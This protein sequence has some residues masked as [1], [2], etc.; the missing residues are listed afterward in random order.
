VIAGLEQ[1]EDRL[2][3][4]GPAAI[5]ALARLD[6][7]VLI[8]GV[9]GKMG[10]SLARM[11]VRAS[12]EAGVSRRVIGVS[13]FSNPEPRRQLQ[14]W[15]VE[16]VAGDLFDDRFIRVLPACPHVVYMVG[17]KFG[18]S[19][20]EPITWATN[21]YLPSCVCRRFSDS[22]IA[23]F[24]TGN[25]YRPMPVEGSRGSGE[26]DALAP[27]GEYAMSCLGRERL[28]EYF[29]RTQGTRLT[30]LR[31]NYATEMRY[32]VLVDI[33]QKVWH[34]EEVPLLVGYVNVIWQADANTMA[35]AALA[36]AAS[37]PF[38]VNITGPELISCRRVAERFG[39]LMRKPVRFS[40]TEGSVA[41]HSDARLAH[42]R[43]GV[44]RVGL[45]ELIGWTADWVM[46]NGPTLNKP[47]HYE[48]LDGQF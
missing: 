11:V 10:P 25:V 7:D 2:S 45:D 6:G 29:S 27:V 24:S 35:L 48:V 43:F 4:P 19:G 20:G 44:P 23:A 26:S 42:E 15:G 22:R 14:E 21:T 18:T 36:D 34:S 9:A 17:R 47:T 46:R 32:G 5:D 37:P 3:D 28:F 31:L 1:L 38:V 41:L 12:Q 8:L 30:I 33:A 13:R 16:T 39:A 40:G